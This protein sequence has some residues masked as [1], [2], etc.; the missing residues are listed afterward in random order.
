MRFGLLTARAEA[1]RD[2]NTRP[3]KKVRSGQS[4]RSL[5]LRRQAGAGRVIPALRRNRLFDGG[6]D[7][8]APSVAP[9]STTTPDTGGM[10]RSVAGGGWAVGEGCFCAGA[11]QH[12]NQ[13]GQ[14]AITTGAT[15]SG[16]RQS[17]PRPRGPRRVRSNRQLTLDLA[18]RIVES[19]PIE[20]NPGN[21]QVNL[22]QRGRERRRPL[23]G[24][25]RKVRAPLVEV[26]TRERLRQPGSPRMHGSHARERPLGLLR[27]GLAQAIDVFV[28]GG[29]GRDEPPVLERRRQAR[30]R[31]AR[32]RRRAQSNGRPAG[33][34][35]TARF[36][37]DSGLA[38][39]AQ[40]QQ[41]RCLP[42]VARGR[43][44]DRAGR[45]HGIRQSLDIASALLEDDAQV[46]MHESAFAPPLST[47]RNAT[48]AASRCRLSARDAG[49][50][51]VRQRRG[52]P[53][54]RPP[55]GNEQGGQ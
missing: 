2:R 34:S 38:G 8:P 19:S 29:S 37:S 22:R 43:T 55:G 11:A 51:P 10:S 31:S 1:A 41:G 54:R 4:R 48:S 33:I 12:G 32:T 44:T 45:P 28:V 53:A 13:Q 20:M 39:P 25:G 7:D 17:V 27:I 21:R 14:E 26:L 50:E 40:R 9:R 24:R 5:A 49:G 16:R 52:N 30:R 47:S 3:S 46:V 6:P 35:R 36:N 18:R 42:A 15:S 23:E